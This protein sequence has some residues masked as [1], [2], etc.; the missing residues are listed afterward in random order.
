MDQATYEV[1]SKVEQTHWWFVGRRKL[2][3]GIIA[4][5]ELPS[6]ATILD[7]GTSTGTNLRLL[8]DMG[9]TN[10][11][12]L[13]LHE[14]A[15]H[16]CAEKGLGVVRKGDVC[17]IPFPDGSIDL[18]LAT[19]IIE[20]VDDDELALREIRRVLTR[21]GRALVTVPAFESLWGLQDDVSQHKRRYRKAELKAKLE[22]SE[23]NA[24]EC[25]YFNY[26]LFGPIWFARQLLKIF[27]IRLKSENQINLG[28][29]NK[30]LGAIFLF[31]IATSRVVSPCFGVS[32]LA[33][34]NKSEAAKNA[35]LLK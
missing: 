1:E 16:W 31:D 34:L 32:I 12:G 24:L 13:D 6:G 18:V 20:H 3:Q 2:F 15:I 10:V 7:I 17:N 9:F 14:D 26:I 29:M 22:R 4:E 5:L 30:I 25:F 35:E 21:N 28:F 23:L 11:Q 19:D 27:R 8:R 33:L